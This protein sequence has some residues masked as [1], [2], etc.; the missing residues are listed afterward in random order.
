[1]GDGAVSTL[2]ILSGSMTAGKSTLAGLLGDAVRADVI[3]TRQYLTSLVEQ[4]PKRSKLQAVGDDLDVQTGGQ[5]VVDLAQQAIA[6]SDSDVVILDAVRTLEQVRALRRKF[7]RT[8]VHLHL[9]A[10]MEDLAARYESRRAASPELE[11]SSYKEAA[12]NATEEAIET[13]RDD[14]DVV[15]D[16]S[17]NTERDVLVRAVARLGLGGR[18]NTQTVDVMVGGQFGSEGKGNVAAY[19][20]PEY[21]LLVRSGGPNAGHSI[22]TPRGVH[23][24]HH[25]PSGTKVSD[26]QLLLTSGAVIDVE[27]LLDE[28]KAS[29]ISEDRL[30]IDANAVVIEDSHRQSEA[31][32]GKRI[33]STVSGVGAATANRIVGRGGGVV[34]AK[35]VGA[36]RPFITEGLAVLADHYRRGSKI[37]VE[38]TQGTGLSLLHGSYPYVTS[39]DT[40][41]AGVLA[42]AGI[43]LTRVR[44]SIMVVRAYPIRVANP[45]EGGTSGPLPQEISWNV[46]AERSGLPL[47]ELVKQEHTTRTKRLRRVGE[48]SWTWIDRAVQLNGPTDIALTFAD[49]IDSANQSARRF[50]Q[51]TQDT[52]NF[53]SEVESVASAPVSL[54]ST[55]FHERSVIDRRMW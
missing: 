32:L 10:P 43:P 54:I 8:V 20:A 28:I 55:R 38:G 19:L 18:L 4:N 25:L 46:V 48:F 6:D 7:G 23:V 51:L 50:D 41:V 11:F 34:L 16:T 44:R 53:V 36:L 27:E 14:A 49:Q 13:L 17:R 42:E 9:T 12:A 2:I 31:E 22:W 47:D 5:W 33:S 26:A 45:G 3:S 37:F 30:S 15:I 40:T 1:M 35:D 24:Q 29:S 39:R 52:I 21:Q